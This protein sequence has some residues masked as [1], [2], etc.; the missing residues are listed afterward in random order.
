MTTTT[1]PEFPATQA[2]K[3]HRFTRRMAAALAVPVL[4]VAGAGIAFLAMTHSGS[5]SASSLLTSDGYTALPASVMSAAGAT[6]PAKDVPF[7]SSWAF[8]VKGSSYEMVVVLTA[9]GMTQVT[10]ADLASIG[11]GMTATEAGNVVRVT[12]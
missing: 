12:G 1:A 2:P 4:A 11:S 5:P 10:P 9:A 8:G 3:A 6:L 7:V